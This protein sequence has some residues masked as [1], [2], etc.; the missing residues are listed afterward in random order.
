LSNI[1]IRLRSI[2]P[3]TIAESARLKTGGNIVKEK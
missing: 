1:R 2:A 3:T